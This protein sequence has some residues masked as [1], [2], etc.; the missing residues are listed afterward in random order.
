MK[1]FY[2]L[3][4]YDKKKNKLSTQKQFDVQAVVDIIN[5]YSPNMIQSVRDFQFNLE[6]ARNHTGAV[7]LNSDPNYLWSIC[8]I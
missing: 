7:I 4:G 1:H 8:Y 5:Y 3:T 6:T 2:I